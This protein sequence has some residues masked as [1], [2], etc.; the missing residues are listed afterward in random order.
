MVDGM[1]SLILPAYNEEANIEIVVNEALEELPR[2]FKSFEIIVVDDGSKDQTPQIVDRL[3]AAR[4][5]LIK[6][7]H[8][9]PNRGYGAALTSG[10]KAAQ[11]DYLMFMD[12]DRQFKPAD[13]KL[14]VP[15]VGK[16]DIIAGYRKKRNDPFYRFLIGY[17]FNTIVTVLFGIHL[18]DI[19]C[20]FKIFKA[21]MLKSMELTSPGALI[22]TEI[23]A[24][25]QR[26]GGSIIEVGVNHYPRLVGH[27]SGANIKVILRAMRE[28]L[29]LWGRMRFYTVPDEV[30]AIGTDNAALSKQVSGFAK[31]FPSLNL[32]TVLGMLAGF[33]AWRWFR[34]G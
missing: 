25:A 28:T 7:I 23:H 10:F 2:N 18:R 6:A 21:D 33:L 19:D 26:Q 13:L 22:N 34:R 15:Y 31:P 8:H 16:A 3:A 30:S 9:R 5:E 4:P 1:L 29:A 11:G 27:Q 24:K 32:L 14:L 20:G 12:S 17:T